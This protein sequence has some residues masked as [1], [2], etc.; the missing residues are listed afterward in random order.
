[1][2]GLLA[3][4]LQPCVAAMLAESGAGLMSRGVA[5]LPLHPRPTARLRMQP[6]SLLREG[7]SSVGGEAV[8]GSEIT[9]SPAMMTSIEKGKFGG[10]SGGAATLDDTDFSVNTI[11][12]QL[13][14]IQQGTPKN[15]VKNVVQLGHDQLPLD[16]AS[17]ICNSELL[18]KGDQLIVFAFHD[19][20]TLR[21]TIEEAKAMSLLVTVLFLD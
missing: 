3:A 14:S 11:L 8:R 15:I 17:R 20:N 5:S 12:K 2:R 7:L 9:S 16:A 10:G 6:Q 1:M 13:E 19:S 21:E 4:C 18:S